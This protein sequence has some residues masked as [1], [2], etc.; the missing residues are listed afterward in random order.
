MTCK[1][2][3]HDHQGKR[4][5]FICIGCPCDERPGAE[6]EGMYTLAMRI[7]DIADENCGM[8][9]VSTPDEL[10]TVIETTLREQS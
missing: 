1:K 5:G 6:N 8:Q 4:L 2:C 7:A 3:G 10:L 9:P